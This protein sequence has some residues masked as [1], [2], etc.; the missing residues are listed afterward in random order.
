MPREG[1][2]FAWR[3]TVPALFTLRTFLR[4]MDSDVPPTV[5]P[6]KKKHTSL[7]TR[8]FKCLTI[9]IKTVDYCTGSFHYYV[10]LQ[11]IT[12]IIHVTP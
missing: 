2:P 12:K 9:L 4:R 3:R 11:S 10:T 6:I 8:S 1:A 7:T 5:I